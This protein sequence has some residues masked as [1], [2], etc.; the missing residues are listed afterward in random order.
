[1]SDRFT[2]D[3]GGKYAVPGW[4]ERLHDIVNRSREIGIRSCRGCPE[5]LLLAGTTGIDLSS[6]IL[7]RSGIL[8][9]L[10]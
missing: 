5:D 7:D 3:E 9:N 4:Y 8:S 10:D 6:M 2:A 1:M